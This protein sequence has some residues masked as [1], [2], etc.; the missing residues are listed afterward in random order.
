MLSQLNRPNKSLE[1][2]KWPEIGFLATATALERFNGLTP[3]AEAVDL[4]AVAGDLVIRRVSDPGQDSLNVG[5]MDIL[6]GPTR[7]ANQM[8]VVRLVTQPVGNRTVAHDH[9]TH[10]IRIDQQL[11]CP[12]HGRPANRR[13]CRG[14][15]FRGEV[16]ALVGNMRND[17]K[18]GPGD[19]ETVSAQFFEQ[20]LRFRYRRHDLIIAVQLQATARLSL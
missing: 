5:E 14:W 12:I 6:G 16:F 10:Q 15:S 2:P 13:Q 11:Q 7:G 9:A 18:P 8:M 4:N 17:L 19:L 20:A 3:R 1:S